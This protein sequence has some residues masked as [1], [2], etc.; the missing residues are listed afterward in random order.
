MKNKLIIGG[1]ATGKTTRLKQIAGEFQGKEVL[2]LDGKTDL[3][4]AESDDDRFCPRDEL[5]FLADGVLLFDEYDS[6]IR[7]DPSIGHVVTKA[8]MNS[9]VSVVLAVQSDKVSSLGLSSQALETFEWINCNH[10]G[11]AQ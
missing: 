1:P 7:F 9:N 8:A 6:A 10:V 5:D 11:G 3:D 4:V 2:F